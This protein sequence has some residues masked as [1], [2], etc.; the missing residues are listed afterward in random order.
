MRINE[1]ISRESSG[2]KLNIK[3]SY[4]AIGISARVNDKKPNVQQE[5]CRFNTQGR[6][7]APFCRIQGALVMRCRIPYSVVRILRSW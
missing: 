7:L 5:P 2:G 4:K 6:I 3:V 1:D